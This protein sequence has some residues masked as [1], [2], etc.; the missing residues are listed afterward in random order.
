MFR[1]KARGYVAVPEYTEHS[2]DQAA[3]FP[4]PFTVLRL[5]IFDDRLSHRQPNGLV[6]LGAH[7]SG[8]SCL[9]GRAYSFRGEILSK[10]A[11]GL[12]VTAQ[13]ISL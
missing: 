6:C 4:V 8:P 7:V 3:P 9:L 13:R 12:L 5:E 1:G 11:Q 2:G 10:T